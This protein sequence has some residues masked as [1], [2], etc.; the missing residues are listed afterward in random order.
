MS[1]DPIAQTSSPT[2]SNGTAFV[3]ALS[4]TP[5]HSG[6]LLNVEHG[7]DVPSW[8]MSSKYSP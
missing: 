2:H 8:S 6:S 7:A 1:H 3:F 4:G 5:T